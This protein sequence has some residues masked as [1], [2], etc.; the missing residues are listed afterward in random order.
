MPPGWV[1]EFGCGS[2]GGTVPSNGV[3]CCADPR[4]TTHLVQ[5]ARRL[6]GSTH[7]MMKFLAVALKKTPNT[8]YWYR[9]VCHPHTAYGDADSYE[10]GAEYCER[11]YKAMELE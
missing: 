11:I 7:P 10:K 4:P 6:K 9:V 8:G 2:C 5:L 1:K 3:A